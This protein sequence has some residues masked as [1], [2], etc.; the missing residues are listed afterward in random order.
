MTYPRSR[1][2]PAD[3]ILRLSRWI[4]TEI[5]M[6]PEPQAVDESQSVHEVRQ[7]L[8]QHSFDQAP[9]TRHGEIVGLL[10]LEHLKGEDRQTRVSHLEYEQLGH[11]NLV[12][13]TTTLPR[14]FRRLSDRS[15][16]LVVDEKDQVIGIVHV[17]DLN[18]QAV[19]IYFY[20]LLSAVEM[21]LA[22]LIAA[23][24]PDDSWIDLLPQRYKR[25]LEGNF[26]K[27]QRGRVDLSL[28][29]VAYFSDL[30]EVLLA[31]PSLRERLVP[32]ESERNLLPHLNK[33]LR[34]SIMHPVKPLVN[35]YEDV[36]QLLG[37]YNT[38]DGLINRMEQ[39][40]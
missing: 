34:H 38:L 35:R 19:R 29:Q 10:R 3:Q 4:T 32:V 5:V 15:S 16:C 17:S 25:R 23:L 9:V 37:F 33:W 31:D 39:E 22:R 28:I 6:T 11:N 21:E 20:L 26:K 24:Y 40:K 36:R 18:R 12:E 7:F 30:I 1:I 8:K 27:Q 13:A 2:L 14:L